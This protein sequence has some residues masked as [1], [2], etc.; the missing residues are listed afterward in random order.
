MAVSRLPG[1]YHDG[2]YRVG[3][4]VTCVG[5]ANVIDRRSVDD[6]LRSSYH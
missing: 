6:R 5:G 2:G 3:G 1:V 4:A